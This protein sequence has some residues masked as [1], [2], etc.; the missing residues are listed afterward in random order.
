[1]THQAA[2]NA[3]LSSPTRFPGTY[4]E[5][6]LGS[7]STKSWLARHPKAH[8]PVGP[9]SASNLDACSVRQRGGCWLV[10]AVQ[11]RG[12]A[13]KVKKNKQNS[14]FTAAPC[15]CNAVTSQDPSRCLTLQASKLKTGAGATGLWVLGYRAAQFFVLG[16]LS[17]G[18]HLF[19][20]KRGGD[21]RSATLQQQ[22]GEITQS[23]DPSTVLR[24]Q[25]VSRDGNGDEHTPLLSRRCGY[26]FFPQSRGAC[27]LSGLEIW[28]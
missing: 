2:K 14:I 26:L 6:E 13:V 27:S 5:P 25:G 24:P 28:L 16:E 21:D 18:P 19:P 8:K 23:P 9:E 15:V 7:P 12:T 17:S 11:T 3:T 4:I 10:T 22:L 1:M 20:G